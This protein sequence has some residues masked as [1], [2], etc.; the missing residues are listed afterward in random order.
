MGSTWGYNGAANGNYSLG[1]RD[2]TQVIENHMEKNMQNR[3]GIGVLLGLS[4]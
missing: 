4:E 2:I 1:F 3:T